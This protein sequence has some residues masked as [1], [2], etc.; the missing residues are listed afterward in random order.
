MVEEDVK[1]CADG[2]RYSEEM[3]TTWSVKIYLCN[4]VVKTYRAAWFSLTL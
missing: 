1:M 3:D 2:S 4:Q